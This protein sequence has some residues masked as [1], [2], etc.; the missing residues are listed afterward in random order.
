MRALDAKNRLYE[1]KRWIGRGKGLI[2]DGIN[3]CLKPSSNGWLK[4]VCLLQTFPRYQLNPQSKTTERQVY[5]ASS[6][7]RDSFGEA[8]QSTPAGPSTIL[9]V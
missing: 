4:N 2:F 7:D 3:V 9:E 6:C 1:E 8:V 5:Q